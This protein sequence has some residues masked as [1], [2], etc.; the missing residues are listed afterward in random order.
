M[1]MQEDSCLQTRK[2]AS[3][4][5]RTVSTL[6]LDFSAPVTV[7]NK[8][9]LRN[10]PNRLRQPPRTKGMNG[11]PQ[12]S[13]ATTERRATRQALWLWVEKCSH[14]QKYDLEERLGVGVTNTQPHPLPHSKLPQPRPNGV[15]T[16]MESEDRGASDTIGRESRT[17]QSK[18][19]RMDMGGKGEYLA[20]RR[21]E[22]HVKFCIQFRKSVA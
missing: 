10:Q 4:D 1:R 13:M 16:K 3:P 8:C 21:T 6:T 20:Q 11:L 7:R 19:Q 14:C 15:T 5:P 12:F 17:E 9:L 18:D 22:M 2:P